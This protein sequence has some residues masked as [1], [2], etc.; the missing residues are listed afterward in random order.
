M[1]RLRRHIPLKTKLAAALACLLPQADRDYYRRHNATA[2]EILKL[3]EWDHVSLH[4]FGGSDLWWNLDPKSKA[5]HR[6][7]SRR[8]ASIAAKVKRLSARERARVRLWGIEVRRPPEMRQWP[9]T[10]RK[11]QSRPFQKQKSRTK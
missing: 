9:K 3:F 5:Q 7:K 10:K 6:E 8:D 11:L 2:D 1:K 4:C